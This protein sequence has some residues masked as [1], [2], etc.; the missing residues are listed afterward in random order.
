MRMT[1]N[2]DEHAGPGIKHHSHRGLTRVL[3]L[4]LSAALVFLPGCRPAP[5]QLPGSPAKKN[6]PVIGYIC[7]ELSQPWF[8]WVSRSLEITCLQLGA[9]EVITADVKMSPVNYLIALDDMISQGV[10]AVIVCP[11]DEKLGIVTAKKCA[12]AG[13]LLLA[14]SDPLYGED[15]RLLAPAITLDGYA[16]GL[17]I[18]RW[19]GSHLEEMAI[20][21]RQVGFLCLTVKAVRDYIPRHEGAVDGFLEVY[22]GFSTTRIFYADYDGTS[23]AAFNAASAVITAHPEIRY[24]AAMASNDEGA[25]S[26]CRVLEQSGKKEAA[27][28][29]VGGYLARE[30]FEKGTECFK[31]SAYIN[32]N[33]TG[34]LIA[35]AVMDWLTSGIPPWQEFITPGEEYGKRLLSA[36]LITPENY[37]E[38][39]AA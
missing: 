20:P 27:V 3:G 24:W 13:I 39:M 35:I 14:D 34:H 31:A 10:Q 32:A 7:K 26:I 16:C 18:G 19:L 1:V 15:G 17:K 37:Q 21:Q 2:K 23:Q 30:E 28:V 25:L 9:S 5:A 11:P 8:T 4:L 6:G 36:N 12:E 22:P 29:G 33:Q 38:V